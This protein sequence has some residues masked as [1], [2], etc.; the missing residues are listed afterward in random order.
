MREPAMI[1]VTCHCRESFAAAHEIAA[2]I[3]ALAGR[4]DVLVALPLHS[5]QRSGGRWKRH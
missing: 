5:I 1:L 2:P 4:P 3:R